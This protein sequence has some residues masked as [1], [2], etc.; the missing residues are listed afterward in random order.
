MLNQDKRNIPHFPEK[1]KF[2]PPGSPERPKAGRYRRSRYDTDG[3]LLVYITFHRR[4]QACRFPVHTEQQTTR[5]T[6]NGIKKATCISASCHSSTTTSLNSAPSCPQ[7]KPSSLRTKPG[8]EPSLPAGNAF[9]SCRSSHPPLFFRFANRR[10]IESGK[11][12]IQFSPGD[13]RY[14]F[15]LQQKIHRVLVRKYR[16]TYSCKYL[17]SRSSPQIFWRLSL[18]LYISILMTAHPLLPR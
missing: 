17:S 10:R 3:T 7:S 1:R 9:S 13:L 15:T 18:S 14:I 5:P 2:F 16:Y 6:E 12:H 11:R 4:R 8:P